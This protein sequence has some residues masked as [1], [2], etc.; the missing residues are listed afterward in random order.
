MNRLWSG[1]QF[2]REPFKYSICVSYLTFCSLPWNK[3]VNLDQCRRVTSNGVA[4]RTPPS[5]G[6]L[7]CFTFNVSGEK[8]LELPNGWSQCT[9]QQLLQPTDGNR[10]MMQFDRCWNQF[11][12]IYSL[13]N[14]LPSSILRQEGLSVRWKPQLDI[15]NWRMITI[16]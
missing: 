12:E 7:S 5:I 4:L 8:N 9:L 14:P 13:K 1:C 10:W 3:W 6:V 15:N 16:Q 11:H 2:R